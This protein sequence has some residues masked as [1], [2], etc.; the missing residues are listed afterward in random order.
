MRVANPARLLFG[1][2]AVAAVLACLI[3]LIVSAPA[4]ATPAAGTAESAY[5]VPGPW[6]VNHEAGAGCCDTTGAKFDLW[7]PADLGAEGIRHPVITWGNGTLAEPGRY[8]ALLRHLASW[9]FVVIATQNQFNNSGADMRAAAEYLV[10]QNSTAGSRFHR[11][12]D[13]AAIGAAGHSQGATGSLAAMID[14][15]AL[16]KTALPIELPAQRF[17]A[18]EPCSTPRDLRSGSIFYLNGS[19]DTFLSPSTDED[20]HAWPG[21]AIQSD[22]AFYRATPERIA[23]VWATLNR[24]DHNDVQGQ[25]DCAAGAFACA[26]GVTGYLGYVTA[27]L[28]GELAGDARAHS[29]FVADSGELFGNRAWS[30][31]VSNIR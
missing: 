9:G 20:A 4:A 27:W 21:G 15:P 14:D 30:N 16:I 3:V 22:Q 17:C 25:P 1:L 23:K 12:L 6:S 18:G 26:D 10:R 2:C 11:K 5:R 13:T 7:Y 19:A 24:A 31:Q 8:D 28:R 29:V